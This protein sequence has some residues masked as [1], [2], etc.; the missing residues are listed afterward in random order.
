MS[1]DNRREAWNKDTGKEVVKVA[2]QGIVACGALAVF[3]LTLGA[4]NPYLSPS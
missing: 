1:R 2:A 3:A 4:V